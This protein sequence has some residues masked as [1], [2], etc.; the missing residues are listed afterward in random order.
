M[1][2]LGGQWMQTFLGW[3]LLL[4]AARVAF[5]CKQSARHNSRRLVDEKTRIEGSP[6][7]NKKQCQATE[8]VALFQVAC[9]HNTRSILW[10]LMEI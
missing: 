9:M 10:T 7:L 4:D 1:V 8:A 2:E 6:F 5:T 3:N